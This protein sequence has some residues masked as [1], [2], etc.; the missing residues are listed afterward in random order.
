VE[1]ALQL[2]AMELNALL[3]F[4]VLLKDIVEL[5]LPIVQPRIVSF[6]MAL[7]VMQSELNLVPTATDSLKYHPSWNKYCQHCPS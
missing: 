6:N 3:D 4:V 1:E 7:R 2:A 5:V